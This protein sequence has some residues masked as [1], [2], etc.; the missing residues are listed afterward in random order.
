MDK[1]VNYTRLFDEFAP[2]ST[3]QWEEVI[4]KDLKGADY[5][6]KLVW[7]TT[8]G[9]AVKPYY[10][11]EDLKNLTFMDSVPG[12]FP[13]LRGTKTQDNNW[14]IRQDICA[15]DAKEANAKAKEV[16]AKGVDSVSFN[17]NDETKIDHEFVSQLLAD[18]ELEKIEVN[19]DA[20][21]NSK[22]IVEILVESNSKLEGSVNFN[23]LTRLTLN[24]S[25]CKSADHSFDR[26]KD[27]VLAAKE[28]ENFRSLSVNGDVFH[29]SGA[30]V[31]QELAFSLSMG[32][33]YMAQLTDRGLKSDTIASNMKFNF[34]IG[35]NYFMEIAKLRAARLLW[36]KVVE[37]FE[38]EDL[39][40]AAMLTHSTTS[41]WN[42]TVYDP[43][44]NMLR[45]TT[46]AM[47]AIIGGT[48]SLTVDAFNKT[49]DKPT[50]FGNRIARNQQILLKE[51]TYLD[52]IADPSAG[53]YYIENLTNSI[54]DETWKLFLELEDKGG[55]IKALEQGFIQ[56]QIKESADKKNELLAQRREILLG[57]NQY[58]NFDE[59]ISEPIDEK[60]FKAEEPLTDNKGF[61][62]LRPYRGAQ[63]FES[64][65]Y[66]TDKY[67]MQ[68]DRPKAFMITMG[69]L[70]MRRA[71]AQFASNFFACA[72]IEV[73]DNNGFKSVEEAVGAF[74]ASKSQIAVICGADDDYA[75]IAPE[76]FNA[77]KDEAITVVAGAPAC[78]DELKSIGIENF[79]HVKVNVLEELKR[80]QKELGI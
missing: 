52:K 71:R 7:R 46:E 57:T 1:E 64:L 18:L 13:F 40:N 60:I 38:V 58:P 24:G 19:F 22:E 20:G 30:N 33:E 72:G 36:S 41:R 42:K 2:V 43:Y 5:N 54:I 39:A 59:K 27:I 25:F 74:R 4:K 73:I 32:A 35:A 66:K 56:Q 11:Q 12:D 10:R 79:I 47:S 34:S 21:H 77:I 70:A 16:C 44:V 9:F 28:L 48:N 31:V 49:F 26:A 37:S 69:S 55:Y 50:D 67:A 6:K 65:R 61:T 23:P 51:E 8:E 29:N 53:S 68:N 17:I 45:T 80:Y 75:T 15:G 78:A 63:A 76:V 14:R 3:E 62:P